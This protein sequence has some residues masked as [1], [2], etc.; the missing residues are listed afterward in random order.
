MR[1]ETGFLRP[2]FY[3]TWLKIIFKKKKKKARTSEMF[4]VREPDNR[5]HLMWDSMP[6]NMQNNQ[7]QSQRVDSRV[8][9][10]QEGVGQTAHEVRIPTRVM[11]LE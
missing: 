3:Q 10:D 6:A 9:V 5:G 8:K 4:S 2:G 1:D 7:I 11:V